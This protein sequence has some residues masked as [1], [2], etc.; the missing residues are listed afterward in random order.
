MY[1]MYTSYP[2]Y[3]INEVLSEIVIDTARVQITYYL[4][5]FEKTSKWLSEYLS[6]F[7]TTQQVHRVS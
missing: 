1:A 7:L 5:A 2:W 3:E 6:F 4:R